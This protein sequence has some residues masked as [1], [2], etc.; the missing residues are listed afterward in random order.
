MTVSPTQGLLG[1]SEELQLTLELT[2]HTEVSEAAWACLVS[3][4]HPV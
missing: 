4:W 3:G 1:P 2:T